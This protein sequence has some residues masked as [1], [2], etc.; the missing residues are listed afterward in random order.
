MN[1][2]MQIL[3]GLALAVAL[4]GVHAQGEQAGGFG[5]WDWG[6]I[7][8][9]D[10]TP[11]TADS[12]IVR[13]VEPSRRLSVE[14]VTAPD[15]EAT[16][17]DAYLLFAGMPPVEVIPSRRDEGMYPCANC[18]QIAKPNTTPRQLAQPHD[19]F[20]LSHGLHGKGEFWC[21]TCHDQ[22]YPGQLRALNNEIVA[23]ED[24][25]II[26]SQCHVNQARDWAYGAHGKRHANWFGDRQV[27]NCTACHYQHAPAIPAREALPG[28]SM[29][30][31]LQRPAHW[32]P[33]GAGVVQIHGAD[34]RPWQQEQTNH[35]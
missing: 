17:H 22:S 4:C 34:T 15:F 5:D 7:E 1:T 33:G 29:R 26:C 32:S 2:M 30:M 14:E 13:E 27:Y 35:E 19:N 10:D 8:A 18:H 20:Q 9:I 24:A 12:V 25:Y 11:M 28:P 21:F 23:F 16:P 3:A 31:A 6:A